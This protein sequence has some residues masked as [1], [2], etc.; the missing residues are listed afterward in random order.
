MIIKI[1]RKLRTFFVYVLLWHVAR[2]F[3][4]IILPNAHIANLIRGRIL[5][6]FFEECGKH[7]AIAS[8]CI[9]NSVWNLRIKDGTYIAHNCW[10]NAAA[11]L[12]IGHGTILSPN[13]V[14]ATTAHDRV[15]GSVSLKTSRLSQIIIGNGTWIASNSVVTKGSI[16]GNGVIVG[17]GSV[18]IG[19]LADNGFFAGNPAKFI[20]SLPL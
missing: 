13:V 11:G 9:F 1:L 7:V 8:G 5:G 17:A 6:L 12:V 14:L 15:S 4:D 10:I 19:P 16:I 3:C 20:R 2:T 18:V